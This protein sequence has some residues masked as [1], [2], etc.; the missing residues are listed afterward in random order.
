MSLASIVT[1][2]YLDSIHVIV[3]AGYRPGSG[4]IPPPGTGGT[5]ALSGIVRTQPLDRYLFVNNDNLV[6]LYGVVDLV[7][8]E[9]FD[10]EANDSA[11]LI[12]L[13]SNTKQAVA[14]PMLMPYAPVRGWYGAVIPASTALVPDRGYTIKISLATSEVVAEWDIPV[15][16]RWRDIST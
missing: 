16:A 14:G 5:T 6:Q 7:T 15:K 12:L 9:F 8:G 11:I 3:T 2:G 1:R 13:D 4:V 10:T